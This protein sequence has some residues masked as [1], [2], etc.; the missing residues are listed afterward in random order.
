MTNFT[1]SLQNLFRFVIACCFLSTL[2]LSPNQLRAQCALGCN[3]SIQVSLDANCEAAITPDLVITDFEGGMTPSCPAGVFT[4]QIQD[5][6]GNTLVFPLNPDGFPVID[7]SLIGQT[8]FVSITDEV[9]GNS[10]WGELTVE[11]KIPPIIECVDIDALFC[12]E[13]IDFTPT[14]QIPECSDVVFDLIG[15]NVVVN[16]CNSGLDPEILKVVTSTYVAT[17]ESGNVSEPCTFTYNVLRHPIDLVEGPANFFNDFGNAFTCGDFELDDQ[18]NPIIDPMITGVPYIDLDMDM[19][20]DNS[21]IPLYPEPEL[22]CNIVATFTDQFLEIDCVLKVIRTWTIVEWNCMPRVY[23]PIIQNIEIADN[24]PPTIDQL[25]DITVSSNISIDYSHPTNGDIDCGALTNLPP[26]VLDDNCDGMDELEVTINI[27]TIDG[28]PV[29]F[30]SGNGGLASIPLGVYVV[31]YTVLD[32]CHNEAEMSYFIN[33]QDLTSPVTICDQN[34]VVSLNNNVDQGTLVYV[35]VFD[36]GSFDDCQLKRV[37]GRRMDPGDCDCPTGISGFTYLGR[38]GDSDYYLSD[39]EFT[40]AKAMSEANALEGN[41]VYWSAAGE[42]RF[43]YDAMRDL[44]PTNDNICFWTGFKRKKDDEFDPMPLSNDWA[45]GSPNL[46]GDCVRACITGA[47]N[48]RTLTS[49]PCN[50]LTGEALYQYVLEVPVCGFSDAVVFCCDDAGEDN[51]VVLR[52]IDANCNFNDCMVTVDVQDKNV[53]ILTCPPPMTIDCD[54]TFDLNNLSQFGEPTVLN[55]CGGNIEELDPV[56][57]IDQCNIGTLVRT[58]RATSSGGITATCTQHI[59]IEPID[60]FFINCND[61]NDP[62][63]DIIWPTDVNSFEGCDDPTS[64][65]FSPDSLEEMFPGSGFPQFLNPNTCSLVAANYEDQI[66]TFNPNN[67]ETCFK[68]V[69]TWTVIDWCNVVNG[70]FFTCSFEQVIQLTNS[71]AP[72]FVDANGNEIECPSEKAPVCTFDLD[73]EDGF[74]ELTANAFD[75]CSETNL[76]WTYQIDAFNDGSF[77]ITQSGQGAM[78]NAS[79]KYPIGTHLIRYTFFDQCGNQ[80]SCDQQFSIV[81]CLKP[82]PYCLT[83]LAV[84]LGV[85]IDHQTGDTIPQVQLWANDFDAGSFHV[86]GYDVVAHFDPDNLVDTGIVFTCEDF[87]VDTFMV[88]YTAVD[89]M[90]NPI[91]DQDGEFLQDFCLSTVNVQDNQGLCNDFGNRFSIDGSV[92]TE[93]NEMV[94]EVMIE[95]DGVQADMELTNNTGEFA[96]SDLTEGGNIHV[97]PFKDDDHLNGVSTL[98][99]VLIQRHV[100]GI[101]VIDSPYRTLAADINSDASVSA[102]DIVELRKLILGLYDKF[103]ANDSWRFIDAR[104]EFDDNFPFDEAFPETYSISNLSQDMTIDFV[105]LKVGDVNASAAAS[106]NSIS[107]ESRSG[108]DFGLQYAINGNEVSF[109]ADQSYDLAG[110]E[111]TL[112]LPTYAEVT[113]I[114]AGQFNVTKDN[115]GTSFDNVMTFSWNELNSIST[116]SDEALFTLILDGNMNQEQFSLSHEFTKSEAYSASLEILDISLESRSGVTE[117]ALFQNVP[118]PFVDQTN[119]GFSIPSDMDIELTIVDVNGKLVRQINGN[120]PAGDNVIT[121]DSEGLSGVHYYTIRA[122]QFTA[123]RKMVVIK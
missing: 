91:L 90:G 25:P 37:V 40:A 2:G 52:A 12:F 46:D 41:V 44:M 15:S 115:I 22:A 6:H 76:T 8:A 50:D 20:Q 7:G 81:N 92:M 68:I 1:I 67:D 60:P 49:Q 21:D 79:D 63:D 114:Q 43:V 107:T 72:F 77:D 103:P 106:I 73:C 39:K 69:R 55:G 109:Y 88:W 42:R 116:N 102:V 117:F 111:F 122:N 29:D 75:E 113:D 24:T 83:G 101:Q 23:P 26:A 57:D 99:I 100:L 34:T 53:P 105:G 32:D 119:I 4:V 5:E 16:D 28:D 98:D 18:G 86:C 33:V 27:T 17:D 54:E 11:D 48:N 80:V 45:V 104:F 14:L 61:F 87:G 56:L 121:I 82:T 64:D 59:N 110:M 47:S 120:Y 85:Y 10:C 38:N 74:I 112:N 89:P 3:G 108:L 51:M 97:V 96:F 30:V 118:N 35:D 94:S 36:E 70:Q 123:T 19:T 95:L 71:D 13:Q 58:F 78:I 65:D 31:T 9:S 93:D 62:N 66:F 84:D